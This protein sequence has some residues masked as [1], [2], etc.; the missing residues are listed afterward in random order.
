[1]SPPP[2][3]PPRKEYPLAHNDSGI[4]RCRIKI[5]PV[6]ASAVIAVSMVALA[7]TGLVVIFDRLDRQVVHM[8]AVVKRP[9]VGC[10]AVRRGRLDL[11]SL[12]RVNRGRTDAH[13]ENE[14]ND[15]D[16]EHE[17]LGCGAHDYG[18]LSA[19]SPDRPAQLTAATLGAGRPGECVGHHTN[20]DL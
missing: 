4:P 18:F 17:R 7:S 11:S 2:P 5:A 3:I 9:K 19:D 12:P 8:S 10:R 15:A 6:I 13:G 20:V 14:A 1:M 16:L